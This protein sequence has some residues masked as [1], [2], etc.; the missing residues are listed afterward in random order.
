MKIPQCSY[1]KVVVEFTFLYITHLHNVVAMLIEFYRMSR[2][3]LN[4][5]FAAL[6]CATK[7]NLCIYGSSAGLLSDKLVELFSELNYKI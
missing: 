4:E 5:A 3:L 7:R 6:M 2:Q 1:I